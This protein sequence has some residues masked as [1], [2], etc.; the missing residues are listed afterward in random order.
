MDSYLGLLRA[1]IGAKSVYRV[2]DVGAGTGLFS[3]AIAADSRFQPCLV[4]AVDSAPA[5][6]QEL[7][8]RAAA[9][10]ITNITT[11]VS[12]INEFAAPKEKFDLAVCSE[13]IHLI[14]DFP[15]FAQK[16]K[17][18]LSPEGVLAIRTS[19]QEQLFYRGWYADFPLA[20]LIDMRRHKTIEFMH[21]TLSYLGFR[22]DVYQSDESHNYSAAEYIAFMKDKP[23]STLFLLKEREFEDG[24][25]RIERRISPG[26]VFRFDYFMTMLI[27]TRDPQW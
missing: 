25:A 11:V 16:L 3:L 6:L 21:A 8:H 1:H 20:R 17:S 7:Q 2:L 19:S 4:T 9:S 27:A 26:S 23:F 15:Q 10:S 22:V 12:D 14:D 13:M 24:L 18:V 5:M